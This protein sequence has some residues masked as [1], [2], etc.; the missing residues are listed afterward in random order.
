MQLK[1]SK[2]L[3]TGCDGFIGSHL[4]EY[5]KKKKAS[6][7]GFDIRDGDIATVDLKRK[8]QEVDV[9]IHLAAK[10]FVPE[11]WNNP[12]AYYHTNFMGTLNVLEFCRTR[13]CSLIY[14]NTYVYGVPNY[15][16]IDELHTTV[17]N[18]PY[19][20]GKM[21]AEDLCEFYG[22]N[23]EIDIT[24]LR[25]FNVYGPQQSEKFLIPEIILQALDSSKDAIV[26]ND[27]LPRRDY[28]YVSDLVIAIEKAIERLGGFSVY[29][30][31]SGRSYSVKE[32][33]DIV[34]SCAGTDKKVMTR[35]IVRKNEVLDVY[36]DI[37]K[38]SKE[39]GFVPL[40][41][42]V[43]GITETLKGM[44]SEEGE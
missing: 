29:N 13:K 35:D 20:H 10:T 15:L 43:D 36:A 11:S 42:M 27:L 33:I 34:Q 5:L 39:L 32:V 7:F 14:L 25:I 2:I 8:Y 31:G 19:N 21:L 4:I 24:V 23:M 26:V 1:G 28:I 18:T 41:A 22:A 37:S 3:V 12:V 16:P 30:I 44:S 17:S 6:V 9:V 40:H 38:A